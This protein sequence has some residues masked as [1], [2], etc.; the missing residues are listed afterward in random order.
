MRSTGQTGPAVAT[1]TSHGPPS[2]GID[3]GDASVPGLTGGG[4]TC[5]SGVA[6]RDGAEVA[7]GLVP[8]ALAGI[9]PVG[10][11]AE[12][13]PEATPPVRDGL[14][15]GPTTEATALAAEEDAGADGTADAR[16]PSPGD[17]LQPAVPSTSTITQRAGIAMIRARRIAS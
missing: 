14:G 17:P 12:A 9:D 6:E 2:A 13:T 5:G 10:A 15:I 16:T 11:P 7:G 4:V 8:F 1:P 3:T